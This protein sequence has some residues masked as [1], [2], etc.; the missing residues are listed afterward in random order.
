MNG[1]KFLKALHKRFGKQSKNDLADML[2]INRGQFSYITNSANE[3]EISPKTVAGAIHRLQ[4]R[5]V[6]GRAL[7]NSLLRKFKTTNARETAALLGLTEMTLSNWHRNPA[8]TVNQVANA[9]FAAHRA[10]KQEAHRSTIRPI[11]E[12]FPI[13]KKPLPKSYQVFDSSD[14]RYKEQL[15][16]ALESTKGLYIF[17]DSAGCALYAGQTKKQ[18]L[19]FEMN[20]A[21]NRP[22]RGQNVTLV[23]HPINNVQF[24]TAHERVRQLKETQRKLYDLAA[25]FSAYEVEAAMIDDLE[26]LLVRAFPNDLSN[27]KMEKFGKASKRKRKK[28]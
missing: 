10:G 4:K 14:G 5:G 11:V 9:I 18:S 28:D 25:Y 27:F 15:R 12:F 20:S 26:A 23:T 21:Y 1:D 24:V 22:R 8:L 6:G 16:R 19:W 13:E 17:Y 3:A 7:L 2:G